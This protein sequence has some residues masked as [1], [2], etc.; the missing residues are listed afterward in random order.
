MLRVIVLVLLMLNLGYFAWNEGW[1]RV[2]GAEPALQREPQRLAR[3]IRPEA[4]VLVGDRA[5][6]SEAAPARPVAVSTPAVSPEPVVASAACLQSGVL[7]G[8]Q[9]NVVRRALLASLPE[10][11]WSMDSDVRPA[12]WMVYMGKFPTPA[13]RDKKRAELVSL[14]VPLGRITNADL[15]PG[16]SLGTYPS[17]QAASAA[18]DVLVRKG[19]RSAKVVQEWPERPGFRV[20][21]PAVTEAMQKPLESV[22]VALNGVPLSSCPA[23]AAIP[24]STPTSAANPA[25]P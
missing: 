9:V 4:M 17:R 20:R 24:A 8:V 14:Q 11:A 16:L 15:V 21:L 13:D 7:T 6:A 2:F 5:P 19:V 23:P 10:D 25:K 1:L 3:Q 18:L 12:S 22:K